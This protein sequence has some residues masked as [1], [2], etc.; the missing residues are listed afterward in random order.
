MWS[1][2]SHENSV[3]QFGILTSHRTRVGG[4]QRQT[5]LLHA[6]DGNRLEDVTRE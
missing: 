1:D 4:Y 5:I 2:G 3:V 6:R